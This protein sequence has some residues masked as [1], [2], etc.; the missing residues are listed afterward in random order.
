M[1]VLHQWGGGEG[2]FNCFFFLHGFF[3]DGVFL[4]LCFI[5]LGWLL[6]MM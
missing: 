2:S 3:F 4:F 6:G 5:A 1:V